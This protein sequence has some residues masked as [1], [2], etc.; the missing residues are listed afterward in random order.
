MSLRNVLSAIDLMEAAQ[1]AALD[2]RSN[3]PSQIVYYALVRQHML[4]RAQRDVQHEPLKTHQLLHLAK[5]NDELYLWYVDTFL[6]AAWA[7]LGRRASP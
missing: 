2:T 1:K 4:A 6:P 7:R 5:A 3:A